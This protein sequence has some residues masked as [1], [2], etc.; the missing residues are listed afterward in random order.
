MSLISI[1]E[2]EKLPNKTLI[3]FTSSTPL[4]FLPSSYIYINISP[5][6]QFIQ[7][8][9]RFNIQCFPIICYDNEDMKLSSTAYWVFMALGYE[10]KV[11]YGGISACEQEGAMLT[12]TYPEKIPY[13]STLHDIDLERLPNVEYQTTYVG[14]LPFLLYEVLGSEITQEKLKKLLSHHSIT[15]EY[16]G[17]VVSGPAAAVFG[18]ILTYLN[19][20]D[21]RVFLGAWNDTAIINR[22][23]PAKP[24][25]FYT[26][27]ESVY[28]DAMDENIHDLEEV[29]ES[30]EYQIVIEHYTVPLIELDRSYFTYQLESSAGITCKGC[31]LM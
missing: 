16:D 27:A 20:K 22:K 11:L 14:D 26:M 15:F 7:D 12:S 13:H 23:P 2:L 29:Q 28:Y 10:A 4:L 18:V 6:A 25:T 17:I 3:Y 30:T 21:I 24:D 31:D 8:L 9:R 1:K 19:R 5:L